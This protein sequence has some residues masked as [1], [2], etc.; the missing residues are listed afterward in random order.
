LVCIIILRRNKFVD[1]TVKGLK[2]ELGGLFI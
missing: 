2:F 1:L